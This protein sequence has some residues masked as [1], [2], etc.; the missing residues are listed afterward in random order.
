MSAEPITDTRT[1]WGRTKF[2]GGRTPAMAGA[3]SDTIMLT[4]F[5][6]AILAITGFE[7]DVMWALIG[8][9][10]LAFFSTCVRYLMAKK[11]G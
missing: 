2:A 3:L 4:G 5:T 1:R 7:L 11:R 10:S 6:L 9:I 8:V